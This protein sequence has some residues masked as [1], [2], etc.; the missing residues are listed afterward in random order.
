MPQLTTAISSKQRAPYHLDRVLG[1]V[2]A[3]PQGLLGKAPAKEVEVR[4]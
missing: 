2:E 1:E 4:P 3:N